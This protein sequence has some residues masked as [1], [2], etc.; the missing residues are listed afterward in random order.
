MFSLIAGALGTVLGI[1]VLSAIEKF[2]GPQLPPNTQFTLNARA[3]LFTTA[4]SIAAAM[5]VGLAPAIHASRTN[6]GDALKD[7]VRGSTGERA[8]SM[9]AILIVGEVALS[10]VLL[11]GSTLLLISFLKLQSTSPGFEPKGAATAFVESQSTAIKHL[12]SRPNSSVR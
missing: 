12:G 10:V 3:L 11:V 8:G 2:I 7:Y 9:R 6:V 5:L 4:I 1:F